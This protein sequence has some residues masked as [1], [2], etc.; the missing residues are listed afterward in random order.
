MVVQNLMHMLLTQGKDKTASAMETV[1]NILKLVM[2]QMM[3]SRYNIPAVLNAQ[4][5]VII[6]LL[7]L[8]IVTNL[9]NNTLQYGL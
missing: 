1:K 8:L 3:E 7:S 9:I 2:D 5:E 4:V 6:E